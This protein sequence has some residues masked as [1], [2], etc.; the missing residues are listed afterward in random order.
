MQYGNPFASATPNTKLKLDSEPFMP[1][2][3]AESK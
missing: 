2:P 1:Q 3:P